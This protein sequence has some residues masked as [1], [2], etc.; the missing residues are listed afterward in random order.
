MPQ[1]D[2]HHITRGRVHWRRWMQLRYL[3]Q[4]PS[5]LSAIK[6][7]TLVDAAYKISPPFKN[8]HAREEALWNLIKLCKWLDKQLARPIKITKHANGAR[9]VEVFKCVVYAVSPTD[10]LV[11]GGW[12]INGHYE[13][14]G[15]NIEL[16]RPPFTEAW[17]AQI[18]EYL[19]LAGGLQHSLY[20]P[21]AQIQQVAQWVG[22][23]AY[24]LLLKNSYF[25][26]L[27][28]ERIP[29]SLGLPRDIY[30][31]ALACRHR[32]VGPLLSSITFNTVW[33]NE[34]AF[35]QVAREN[36][37][38]LPLLMLYAES[39]TDRLLP[40]GK[41]PVTMMKE[42]VLGVGLPES[43]WRYLV[44]HG[45]RLFRIPWAISFSQQ[46]G[47][48]VALSYLYALSD[49]GLPPPPPPSVTKAWL[50]S[51]NGHANDTAWI[52]CQFHS[53]IDRVTL[54]VALREADRRRGDPGLVSFVEE[55]LGV[56][57]WS[58]MVA[59]RPNEMQARA[60]WPWF[61]KRWREAEAEENALAKVK[62][63]DW[64]TRLQPFDDGPWQ[65]LP[66]TSS[67]ALVRESMAMRNC[68]QG[69]LRDCESGKVEVYSVRDRVT[70][71]RRA[72]I[73]FRFR[74]NSPRLMDVKGYAN[75]PPGREMLRLEA[76]IFGM[77]EQHNAFQSAEILHA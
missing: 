61:V 34:W 32:P 69:L 48:V 51:Y 30:A 6:A 7:T 40:L 13:P 31:I 2:Y 58:E 57:W 15:S 19:G 63:C 27:R 67:D 62:R 59:N 73:G 56:C 21:H 3:P 39:M 28:N 76:K 70:G 64:K 68:L 11:T 66:I 43:A 55:F 75:T 35:R 42:H 53:V 47:V 60:G 36:P 22:K 41:D 45:T 74:S 20:I 9:R 4:A 29:K 49:A 72:C 17:L 71:K 12:L 26:S 44:H 23:T 65:I 33:Q 46:S 50:H 54:G 77:L 1:T 18:I 14:H 16:G 10:R 38:L 37:Q 25:R 8:S 52:A 24:S 5:K